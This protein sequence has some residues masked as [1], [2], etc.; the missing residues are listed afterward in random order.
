MFASSVVAPFVTRPGQVPR[1]IQ[2]ERKKRLFAAQSVEKLLKDLG[3]DYSKAPQPALS[4]F[5]KTVGLLPLEVF[6]DEDLEERSPAA[7]LRLAT[8]DKDGKVVHVPARGLVLDRNGMGYWRD[9]TVLRWLEKERLYEFLPHEPS[10]TPVQ[11][12]RMHLCFKAE[13]PFN[14]ARRVADAHRRR[15]EAEM[16]LLYNFY[17]DCMPVE[18]L[19]DVDPQQAKRILAIALNT[20]ALQ[21][22]NNNNQAPDGHAALI[23]E[24]RTQA[25]RSMNKITFDAWLRA[26]PRHS[27]VQD[28]VLPAPPPPRAVPKRGVIDLPFHATA[29]SH[30]VFRGT[31]EVPASGYDDKAHA[32]SFNS[33]LTKPELIKICVA[34]RSE[35][36]KVLSLSFF[37]LISKSVRLEEF[38]N[39]QSVATTA[40]S[41]NLKDAWPSAVHNHIR[42]NLK[43]MKK[44]W[45]NLDETNNEVY[46]FS[47]LR[48][49]LTFVNF[50]MQVGYE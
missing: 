29:S 19:P 41:A 37:S 46:A 23:A 8:T 6:D 50:A 27:M 44:G 20:R 35:C 30:A 26:N 49:F 7:W 32:F 31:L 33:F 40:T 16:Q 34:L 39:L 4:I 47:K 38:T 22:G 13:D 21:Q 2:I 36:L 17:I 12:H 1:K 25:S 10:A 3:V 24:V 9:G 42:S 15:Q 18:T 28:L 48:K 43:D 11:L 45:F 14:F 5:S